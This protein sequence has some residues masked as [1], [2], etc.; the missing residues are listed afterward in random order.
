MSDD[1][2][3]GPTRRDL[4]RTAGALSLSVL[5]ACRRPSAEAELTQEA[6]S[7]KKLPPLLASSEP[8]KNDPAE[9]RPPDKRLGVAVVGLGRL[10][11]QQVL[12]AFGAS[13]SCKVAALVTGD[14]EKGR[15]VAAQYGV[16]P[17][18]ILDYQHYDRLKE[19][20]GVDLVYI[21][22]PNSMHAEFTVRAARA[23]KHV[24]CEKPM[25]TSVSDCQQMIDACATAKTKLMIAYRMQYEPYNRE[26]I[27][28]ARTGALGKLKSMLASNGQA[29]GDPQQWRLK[30]ALAGGGA[31][32]DVGIYC[33]NA[34]RYICG[35]EPIEVQAMQ[36]S[37][38]GDPRFTEVEEQVN[39]N[40]RFP[41][42]FTAS[43]YTSYGCHDS[44]R[45][46][47]LGSLGWA[48]LDP[49]FPYSG[50][51]M[52]VARKRNDDEAETISQPRL[53]AK[54]QFA[55]E[56]DHL[57]DCVLNDR[58]PHTPG[59]EGMQDM[60]LIAAIYEAAASG[61]TV[62]LAPTTGIDAFRGPL[63]G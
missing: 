20:A 61:A 47:V 43:C 24:L 39:F 19:L 46:R 14:S 60:K 49:A 21:A 54:N 38:P 52:R 40:L 10:A 51:A 4:L 35:E 13:K 23:G 25:A 26:L 50:Q 48:E 53:E 33:L 22:L 63:A 58:K 41:S 36:Y 27:R 34:A 42:G 28:L 15:A 5:A 31:L 30:K 56:L 37:T 18:T 11:L 1:Q 17:K 6:P 59:E 12:P 16:N 7:L 2:Q 32:P 57:A 9:V 8:E 55:L 45:Y 3:L 62:K 29:Q 44:K